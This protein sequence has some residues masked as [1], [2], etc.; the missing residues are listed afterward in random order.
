MS[1]EEYN[2]ELELAKGAQF[3]MA[4]TA[5]AYH[6]DGQIGFQEPLEAAASL[7]WMLDLWSDY[8]ITATELIDGTADRVVEV[9]RELSK[10]ELL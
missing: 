8:V 5:A 7:T 4:S 1:S 9:L 3:R 6:M 10:P 2:N